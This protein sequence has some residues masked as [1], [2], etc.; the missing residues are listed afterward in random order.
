M[1]LKSV[2][3]PFLIRQILCIQCRSC[4]SSYEIIQFLGNKISQ[5]GYGQIVNVSSGW[6]LFS[7]GPSAYS[8]SKATLNAITKVASRNYPSCVKIN[9]MCPGWVRTRIGGPKQAAEAITW[10]ATIDDN[11]PD[12]QYFR[13]KERINW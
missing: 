4:L 10:L 2:T 1:F 7:D 9:A 12:G 13:D 6:G 3:F 11:G 8:I 5:R